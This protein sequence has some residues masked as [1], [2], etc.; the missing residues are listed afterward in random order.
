MDNINSD[1]VQKRNSFLFRYK[2]KKLFESIHFI[3]LALLPPAFCLVLTVL[4]SPSL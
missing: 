4:F 1:P 2:L 3:L